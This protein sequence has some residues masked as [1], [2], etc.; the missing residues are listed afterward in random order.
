MGGRSSSFN[1]RKSSGVPTL[2]GSKDQI[3]QA[4]K[5]RKPY[6]D[7]LKNLDEDTIYK[8]IRVNRGET[9]EQAMKN[10]IAPWYYETNNSVAKDLTRIRQNHGDTDDRRHELVENVRSGKITLEQAKTTAQRVRKQ[11]Q[12]AINAFYRSE[13]KKLMSHQDASWWISHKKELK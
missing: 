6:A 10:D 13:G 7:A 5:I 4:E 1:S 12:K 8:G 11:T 3:A 9:S 2:H